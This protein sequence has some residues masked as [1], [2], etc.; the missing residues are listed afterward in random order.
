MPPSPPMCTTVFVKNER[1]CR[2]QL[3]FLASKTYANLLLPL[4]ELNQ[5]IASSLVY[6]SHVNR[7][8]CDNYVIPPEDFINILRLS[9]ATFH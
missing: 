3:F 5:E 7:K 6:E 2:L 1:S 8:S 9:P 4:P